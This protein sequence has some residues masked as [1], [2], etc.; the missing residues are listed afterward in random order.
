GRCKPEIVAPGG[1]TSETT[2][3]IAG[4]CGLRAHGGSEGVGRATTQAVIGSSFAIIVL[5][6]IISA[7]GFLL[8][9]DR[10]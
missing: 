8:V 1:L 7:A 2:P 5:D 6:L 3:I 9:G 10:L 4:F